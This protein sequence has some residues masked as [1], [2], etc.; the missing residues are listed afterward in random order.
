MNIQ[1]LLM[2]KIGLCTEEKM[3]FRKVRGSEVRFSVVDNSLE[4]ENKAFIS[5]DTYFNGL[6][7]EKWKN[8]LT[9]VK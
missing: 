4:F 9:L 3:F 8:I 2:P 5:F 6:S 1:N 7:I